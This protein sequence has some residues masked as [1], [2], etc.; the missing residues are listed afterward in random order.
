MRLAERMFTD[1]D[2]QRFA[3]ASGDDNPIHVDAR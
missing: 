1:A 2:Q 3:S